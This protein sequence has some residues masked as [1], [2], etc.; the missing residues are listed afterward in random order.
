MADLYSIWPICQSGNFS[1]HNN[2]VICQMIS[3]KFPEYIT[4]LL[5]RAT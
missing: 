2:Y 1:G 4:L 3:S 5:Y